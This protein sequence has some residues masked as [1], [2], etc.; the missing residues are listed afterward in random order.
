[1]SAIRPDFR[2]NYN[3]A[4]LQEGSRN[5]AKAQPISTGTALS[6]KDAERA[7]I[8][9]DIAA[10]QKRGGKIQ[11]IGNTPPPKPDKRHLRERVHDKFVNAKAKRLAEEAMAQGEEE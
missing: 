4:E 5:T 1:M 7:R 9:A 6:A 2:G 10:F 11:R 8:A 3:R